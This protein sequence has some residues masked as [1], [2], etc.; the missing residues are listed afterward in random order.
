MKTLL[1][2]SILLSSLFLLSLTTDNKTTKKVNAGIYTVVYSED[3]EQPLEVWYNVQCPGGKASRAGL[4]F[5]TNDSI[6]TS[7]NED[8]ENNIYDKGHMAP[9]ADFSC[10]RATIQKTF[11]YLNCALQ[12]QYLNRGV[13]R[14]LEAHEREIALKTKVEVHIIL[15]F[16]SKSIKLPTGATVPSGFTKEIKYGSVTEVYYFLNEKPKSNSYNDYKIK[17]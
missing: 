1:K 17:P 10:D 12:D 15:K 7:S 3:L 11:S 8:Y 14:L 4:D 16:N 6:H 9:A 2:L 5:Y 13:W